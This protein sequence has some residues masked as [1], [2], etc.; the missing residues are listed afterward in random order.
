MATFRPVLLSE[1]DIA[2]MA[3]EELRLR[4]EQASTYLSHLQNTG[5]ISVIKSSRGPKAFEHCTNYESFFGFFFVLVSL[6]L[7]SLCVEIALKERQL[8][9]VHVQVEALKLLINRGKV[10]DATDVNVNQLFRAIKDTL[11]N[12]EKDSHVAQEDL[13]AWTARADG[14]SL[15][16]LADRCKGLIK[17]NQNLGSQL[18][19]DSVALLNGEIKEQEDIRKNLVDSQKEL[20][21]FVSQLDEQLEAMCCKVLNLKQHIIQL[22]GSD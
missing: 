13:T 12:A 9:S 18:A 7:Y 6:L 4:N 17:I 15:R 21:E 2:H 16:E 14:T 22:Q 1:S 8:Q 11:I 10:S 3:D 5:D 20:N 19:V